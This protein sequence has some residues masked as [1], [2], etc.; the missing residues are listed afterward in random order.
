MTSMSG[1]CSQRLHDCNLARKHLCV[2]R[3][4]ALQES[5]PALTDE[6]WYNAQTVSHNHSFGTLECFPERDVDAFRKMEFSQGFAKK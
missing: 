3:V 2:I 6:A 1:S 4:T 5:F